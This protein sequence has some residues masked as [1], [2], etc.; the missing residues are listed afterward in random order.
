L[1]DDGPVLEGCNPVGSKVNLGSGLDVWF[2]DVW[3][4]NIPGSKVLEAEFPPKPV[5]ANLEEIQTILVPGLTVP[6][7]GST[8]KP[9][10]CLS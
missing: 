7:L 1:E 4:T 6:T 3:G 8:F 10:F 5:L 2:M 9:E